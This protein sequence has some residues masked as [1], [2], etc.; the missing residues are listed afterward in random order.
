MCNMAVLL[1]GR[2]FPL[3][4]EGEN[5]YNS[6]LDFLSVDSSGHGSYLPHLYGFCILI[7]LD[8]MIV[9]SPADV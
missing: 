8:T 6:P 2:R 5:F 3:V 4:S 7:R 1:N 9:S